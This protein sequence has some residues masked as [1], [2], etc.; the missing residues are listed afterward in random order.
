MDE[1]TFFEVGMQLRELARQLSDV[2]QLIDDE[3]LRRLARQVD[4]IGVDEL[5]EDV[6]RQQSDRLQRTLMGMRSFRRNYDYWERAIAEYALRSGMTQRDAARL[7][8]VSTATIN[9]WNQHPVTRE[10]ND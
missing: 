5:D 8:G 3:E 1:V 9:R 2:S 7:L 4:E 10:R 6:A